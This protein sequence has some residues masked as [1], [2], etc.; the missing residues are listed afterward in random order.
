MKRVTSIIS[1]RTERGAAAVELA[2][3]SIVFIPLLLAIVGFGHW[4]YTMEMAAEATRAGARIAVVCD[5]NDTKIRQAVQSRIPQLG[6]TDAQITVEYFPAGCSK[7]NC[8]GVRVSLTGASYN[9]WIPFLPSVMPM[10]PVTSSLP[11]ESLESTNAAGD[12][13]PVCI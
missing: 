12:I 7:S 10:P 6:L 9:S 11:R 1:R 3:V 13:N 2:L 4:A 8:Q 5:L